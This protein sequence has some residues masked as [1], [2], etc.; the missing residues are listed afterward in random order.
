MLHQYCC[1]VVGSQSFLNSFQRVLVADLIDQ[2]FIQHFQFIKIARQ[3]GDVFRPGC[4]IALLDIVVDE[5][6]HR[7]CTVQALIDGITQLQHSQVG[8]DA[9][10]VYAI[11]RVLMELQILQRHPVNPFTRMRHLLDRFR[12]SPSKLISRVR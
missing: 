4:I 12:L 1:P 2:R 3:C 5:V 11:H 9:E 7:L 10:V 6:C 8:V